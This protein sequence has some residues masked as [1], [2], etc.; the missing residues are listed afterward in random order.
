MLR[1]WIV[2]VMTVVM[3][4]SWSGCAQGPP[5]P[6]K[7]TRDAHSKATEATAEPTE[8]G[9]SFPKPPNGALVFGDHRKTGSRVDT[10]G[11]TCAQRRP[12]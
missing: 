9:I 12:S 10:A 11:T 3:L 1:V 4:I 6:P 2:A 5:I 8:T 7:D